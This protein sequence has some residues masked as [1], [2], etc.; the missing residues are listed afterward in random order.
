MAARVEAHAQ[1]MGTWAACHG[2]ATLS[3]LFYFLERTSS[4]TALLFACFTEEVVTDAL[5]RV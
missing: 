1:S 3:W 5:T 4:L 2:S